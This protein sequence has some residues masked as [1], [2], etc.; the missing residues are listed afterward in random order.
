MTAPEATEHIRH[1][2]T[3]VSRLERLGFIPGH[4]YRV[5]GEYSQTLTKGQAIATMWW[6]VGEPEKAV[7]CVGYRGDEPCEECWAG[8]AIVDRRPRPN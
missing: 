6:P 1:H 2:D 7:G 4:I 5:N 8:R 3:P